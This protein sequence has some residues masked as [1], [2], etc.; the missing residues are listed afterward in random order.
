[1]GT[2][3]NKTSTLKKKKKKPGA[4]HVAQALVNTQPSTCRY[5]FIFYFSST[6]L[7]SWKVTVRWRQT[8]GNELAT[9]GMTV[10]KQFA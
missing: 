5:L 1:M 8:D 4:W 2:V 7:H 10:I 9:N 3:A 6:P